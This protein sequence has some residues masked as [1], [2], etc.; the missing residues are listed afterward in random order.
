MDPGRPGLWVALLMGDPLDAFRITVLFSVEQAAFAGLDAGG[1][2]CDGG[3]HGWTWLTMLV[4][5]WAV[6]GFAT[7]LVGARRRL[8]A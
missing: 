6:G 8:D 7:G 1:S 5:L 4:V 3:S 2:G